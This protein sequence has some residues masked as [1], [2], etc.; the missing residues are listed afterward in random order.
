MATKKAEKQAQAEQ[1]AQ[2]EQ[3][4]QETEGQEAKEEKKDKGPT[5]AEKALGVI[6]RMEDG[7]YLI[8]FNDVNDLYVHAN[9]VAKKRDAME[10]R[11][12]KESD[13]TKAEKELVDSLREIVS[14]PQ[15]VDPASEPA[16]K[17][18]DR[19]TKAKSNLDRLERGD[20]QKRYKKQHE[21]LVKEAEIASKQFDLANERRN[22]QIRAGLQ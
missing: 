9:D 22:E 15:D 1:E 12:G 4:A 3:A 17:A 16:M 7:S 6:N 21:E 8:T 18:V 10:G 20:L 19:I 14:L 2:E 11:I 5:M 13:T